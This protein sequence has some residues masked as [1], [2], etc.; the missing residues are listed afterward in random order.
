MSSVSSLQRVPIFISLSVALEDLNIHASFALNALLLVSTFA[1]GLHVLDNVFKEPG[2][3][4]N[5]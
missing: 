3:L 5:T 4:K 1:S 2:K